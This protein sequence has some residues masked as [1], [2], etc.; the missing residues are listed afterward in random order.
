[1]PVLLGIGPKKGFYENVIIRPIA[2]IRPIWAYFKSEPKSGSDYPP[3]RVIRAQFGPGL[4]QV[5]SGGWGGGLCLLPMGHFLGV[6]GE[7]IEH[8]LTGDFE[9][10]RVKSIHRNFYGTLN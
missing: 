6:A 2:K 7:W 5:G 3:G 4:M 10:V 9:A 8:T 1:M